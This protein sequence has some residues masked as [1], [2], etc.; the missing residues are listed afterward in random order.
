MSKVRFT[1]DFDYKPAS[2]VTVAYRAGME[3]TVKRDCAEQAT[4][5]GKAVRIPAKRKADDG[6]NQIG[7]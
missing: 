7:G 2:Q 6:E 3:R 1:A 4:A 5:A